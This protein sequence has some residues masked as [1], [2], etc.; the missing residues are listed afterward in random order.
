M[1]WFDKD[2]RI[3]G[4][5][6]FLKTVFYPLRVWLVLLFVLFVGF[7]LT[8]YFKN[9]YII[10][11]MISLSPFYVNY[12]IGIIGTLGTLVLTVVISSYSDTKGDITSSYNYARG[13]AYQQ[14]AMWVTHFL[15]ITWFMNFIYRLW[16]RVDVS[17]IQDEGRNSLSWWDISNHGKI[18]GKTPDIF[19]SIIDKNSIPTWIFIFLSWFVLSVSYQLKNKMFNLY[20]SVHGIYKD[21]YRLE[22]KD[23]ESYRIAQSIILV[24]EEGI[25]RDN[26]EK[27]LY[28][29]VS[30]L[31]PGEKSGKNYTGYLGFSKIYIWGSIIFM[32]ANIIIYSLQT[33]I[34]TGF[35]HLLFGYN[36]KF[37]ILSFAGISLINTMVSAFITLLGFYGRDIP[38]DSKFF[39]DIKFYI[40]GVPVMIFSFMGSGLNFTSS[41]LVF[42]VK[43]DIKDPDSSVIVAFLLGDVL[44]FTLVVFVIYSWIFKLNYIH[45]IGYCT[46]VLK[47]I[48]FIHGINRFYN[49][50]PK[51]EEYNFQGVNFN[52]IVIAKIVYMEEFARKLYRDLAHQSDKDMN[53]EKDLQLIYRK[54]RMTN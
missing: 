29:Y 25:H 52:V 16:M 50:R 24:K 54:I 2:T 42:Y 48:I 10:E 22:K 53:M 26:Y 49:L 33:V 14:Y 21:I 45:Y 5:K 34:S 40:K 32:I 15:G 30:N 3:E 41:V 19:E 44:F 37:N 27:F 38:V 51:E 47:E 36:F 9:S 13:F 35:L 7:I 31:F 28:S 18:C 11:V 4:W 23:K 46:A 20:Q 6:L 1:E 43:D 17:K 39:K 8:I 12:K